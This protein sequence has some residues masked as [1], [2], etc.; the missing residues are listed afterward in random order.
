MRAQKKILMQGWICVTDERTHTGQR[1]SK[2]PD[3]VIPSIAPLARKITTKLIETF[4]KKYCFS[5]K[6]DQFHFYCEVVKKHGVPCN[7]ALTRN[8]EKLLFL[9]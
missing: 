3:L 2:V 9:S 1:K 8:P 5:T 7:I 6:N 4:M